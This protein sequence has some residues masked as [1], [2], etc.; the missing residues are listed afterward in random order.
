MT[1]SSLETRMQPYQQMN[2]MR[3]FLKPGS[4]IFPMVLKMPK[5]LRLCHHLTENP[6]QDLAYDRGS[7]WTSPHP[8]RT[9]GC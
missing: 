5:T 4:Q 9:P 8:K 2:Q 7:L 3:M 1:M 6:D